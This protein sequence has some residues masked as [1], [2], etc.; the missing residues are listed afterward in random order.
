MVV[1]QSQFKVIGKNELL[2]SDFKNHKVAKYTKK[3]KDV[4]NSW[5]LCGLRIII[6]LV[7]KLI[8]GIFANLFDEQ[9][10]EC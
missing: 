10:S 1:C 3:Y 5:C 4:R 7:F 8:D 6:L 2:N 9:D